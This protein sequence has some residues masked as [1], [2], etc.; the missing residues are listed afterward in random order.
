MDPEIFIMRV[1]ALCFK[2]R[3]SVSSWGRTVKHNKNV[4]GADNSYHLLWL[5]CDVVLDDMIQNPSLEVDAGIFGLKAILEGDHYH[6][7]PAKQGAP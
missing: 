5:G 2:H 3:G 1:F 7:Q 4:G 6:L